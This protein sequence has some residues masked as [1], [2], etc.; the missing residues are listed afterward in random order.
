MSPNTLTLSNSRANTFKRCQ[1]QYEFRYRLKLKPKRV[2]L[3]LRL[4]DWLHQLL[5]VHADGHDWRDRHTVLRA[6]FDKLLNEEKEDLGDLPTNAERLI[7]GY[8][9]H[10]GDD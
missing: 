2:A 7:K 9:A 6:D 4:G 8:L 5:M 10:Y 1:K 3:P